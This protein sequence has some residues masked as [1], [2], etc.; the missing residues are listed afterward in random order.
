MRLRKSDGAAFFS[1]RHYGTPDAPL[2]YSWHPGFN[3][4]EVQPDATPAGN[5]QGHAHRDDLFGAG[6]AGGAVYTAE[7][8][9]K[10]AR[11]IFK[12]I[13]ELLAGFPSVVLGFFALLCWLPG[14]RICSVLS[15][16]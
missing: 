8:A 4:A 11:E 3:R 16:G 1:L 9:S 5:S 6:I 7:F 12:P 15:I 14:F 13:V 2:P 10:W